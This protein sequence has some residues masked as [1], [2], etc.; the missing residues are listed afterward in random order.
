M[1]LILGII[2]LWDVQ[3]SEVK[4]VGGRAGR[5]GSLHANG[6]VTCLYADDLPYLRHAMTTPN[7]SISKAGLFPR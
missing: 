5:F 2:I 3:L 1:I 6:E 4:Q 7:P